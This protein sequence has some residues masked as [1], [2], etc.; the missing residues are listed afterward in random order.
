MNGNNLQQWPPAEKKDKTL[1]LQPNGKLAW[2][3]PQRRKNSFSEYV[4]DPAHPVPYAEDVHFTRTRE[5]MTD[6]QRFATPT[7]CINVSN[8]CIKQ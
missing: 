2:E 1:Y 4:S 5:Y 6:D 8:G 3:K 7:R